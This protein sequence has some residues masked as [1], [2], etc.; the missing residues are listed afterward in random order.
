MIHTT[1]ILN[2]KSK[3]PQILI[4]KI[5]LGSCLYLTMLILTNVISF[6]VG[7][8]KHLSYKWSVNNPPGPGYKVI[9]TTTTNSDRLWPGSQPLC[10]VTAEL[11]TGHTSPKTRVRPRVMIFLSLVHLNQ[12][13]LI[14]SLM[15]P[16]IKI[17]LR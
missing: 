10:V 16:P 8:I 7:Y 2:N 6:C 13:T 11:G 12:L 17:F 5:V 4:L 14:I 1:E 9:T 3:T 15:K